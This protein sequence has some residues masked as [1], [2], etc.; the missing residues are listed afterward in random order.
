M[1]NFSA[2]KLASR[3]PHRRLHRGGL[4]DSRRKKERINNFSLLFSNK[5]EQTFP[6]LL[7]FR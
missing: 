7:L 5:L 4:A 6:T 3:R 2:E 1:A